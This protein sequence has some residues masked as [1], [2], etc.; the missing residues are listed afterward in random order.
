MCITWVL[1]LM[2]DPIYIFSEEF[3]EVE[4]G[5]VREGVKRNKPLLPLGVL[6]PPS[7]KPIYKGQ[8]HSQGP[9]KR[10]HRGQGY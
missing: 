1:Y 9:P 4:R 7:S 8:G 5:G 2:V 10:S 3:V 6:T